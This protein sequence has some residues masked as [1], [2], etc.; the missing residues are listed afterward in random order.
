MWMFWWRT[1]AA[2]NAALQQTCLIRHWP[3]LCSTWK[4]VSRCA[5]FPS[6]Q[7]AQINFFDFVSPTKLSQSCR[8]WKS[9]LSPNARQD[10]AM[11]IGRS[12]V[13]S[14][15]TSLQCCRCTYLAYFLLGSRICSANFGHQSFPPHFHALLIDNRMYRSFSAGSSCPVRLCKPQFFDALTIIPLV[16][17]GTQKRFACLFF[18]KAPARIG[19]VSPYDLSLM[20]P[21]WTG[22]S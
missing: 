6:S 19:E 8:L 4:S 3:P 7:S 21:F 22:M 17:C 10:W 5:S 1:H 9:G 14:A 12:I 11:I 15:P 20:M 16:R 2:C 18:P 13:F